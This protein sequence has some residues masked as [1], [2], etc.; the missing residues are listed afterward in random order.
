[1]LERLYATRVDTRMDGFVEFNTVHKFFFDPNTHRCI[2]DPA[3][4]YHLIFLTT[5]SA[6]RYANFEFLVKRDYSIFIDKI[7]FD[8]FNLNKVA[9]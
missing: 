1:M 4:E 6:L 7:E 5:T 3:S 2:L 8:Y 9:E